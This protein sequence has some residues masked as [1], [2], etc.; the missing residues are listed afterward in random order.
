MWTE[1]FQRAVTNEQI[2]AENSMESFISDRTVFDNL[3]YSKVISEELY[4]ELKDLCCNQTYDKI[5][6]VPIEFDL[7]DDWVRFT[8]RKF[9]LDIQNSILQILSDTSTPFEIVSGSREQ[10]V[11]KIINSL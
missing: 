11:S 9:Q 6:F 10:R 8:D 4:K 5:F 1:S 2:R 3:A 7:E